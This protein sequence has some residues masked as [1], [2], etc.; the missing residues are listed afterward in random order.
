M[1]T[2]ATVLLTVVALQ[3][4]AQRECATASYI[5]HQRQSSS[6]AAAR[7]AQVESFISRQTARLS[8]RENGQ[9]P[10]SFNNGLIRI[11]VVVHVLF[12]PGTTPVSD[13]Q[14]K[15][16][17][18]A[19]N[20]DFRRKNSDSALTPGRFKKLAADVKIEFVL[21]TVDPEGRPTAGIVRKKTHVKEWE[22][23]DHPTD[24]DMIKSSAHC[25]DNP[26]DPASYLNI[27]VGP[28][29]KLLGYSSYVDGNQQLDGIVINP[30]AFGTT[31]TGA[32]FHLGRTAVHEVGHWLGLKHIWGDQDCGDDGVED[33]PRQRGFTSK[34]PSD[35]VP[36][37]GGN[38]TGAMYMNY[39]D[40]TDD[41]CMNLFT[42]GQKDRMRALFAPGGPKYSLLASKGLSTPW[43]DAAIALS[44][45]L[46]CDHV[47]VREV[48][49][50]PNP[51]TGLFTLDFGKDTGWIGN[52]IRVVDMKGQVKQRIKI[53]ALVQKVQLPQL[54]PGIY[55]LSGTNREKKFSS[56]LVK[57]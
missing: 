44:D 17:I 56:K 6:A 46:T 11:P 48:K 20:R 16:Q 39:M 15:S 18:D 3:L 55:L 52:E 14:V 51:S 21:A 1:R 30:R 2:F 8:S 32:P 35:S 41:A 47:D 12:A 54:Q 25:G 24:V 28:M 7:M 29:R 22:M 5:E 57:L 23:P 33:T 38:S 43:N 50:Y 37:C 45:T 53:T 34:C 40:F 31:N 26:W 10:E 27:W 36:A 42:Q 13:A 4:S 19:L 49:P 9:A